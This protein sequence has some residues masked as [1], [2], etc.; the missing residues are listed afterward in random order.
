MTSLQIMFG[1][2]GLWYLCRELLRLVVKGD[3][4]A[5]FEWAVALVAIVGGVIG[6]VM[7]LQ[8][9]FTIVLPWLEFIAAGPQAICH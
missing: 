6:G 2:L 9:L 7:G 3:Y 1:G 8:A 5:W 4:A